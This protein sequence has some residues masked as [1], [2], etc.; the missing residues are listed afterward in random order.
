[1]EIVVAVFLSAVAIALTI[2]FVLIKLAWTALCAVAA[3]AWIPFEG[4]SLLVA[5]AAEALWLPLKI[6]GGLVVLGVLIVG[7]LVVGGLSVAIAL[8]FL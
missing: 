7:I 4:V 2:G 1:M 6:L 8:A 3:A 5:G